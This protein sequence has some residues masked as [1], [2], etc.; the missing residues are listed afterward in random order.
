MAIRQIIT[1]YFLNEPRPGI[2]EGWG[3][4]L[5]LN[6]V[7]HAGGPVQEAIAPVHGAIAEFVA[8]CASQSIVAVSIAGDCCASIPVL[9]GLQR[10]ERNPVLVWLDAHGDFNTWDTSPSGFLGG[11]P[12]AMIAGRG[13]TKLMENVGAASLSESDIYLCDAR[14]LDPREAEALSSSDVNVCPDLDRLL[15]RLPV[16]ADVYV[17]FDSD[18]IDSREV[19]AQSYPVPGGPAASEVETFFAALAHKTNVVAASVSAWH[20]ERDE[21][22]GSARIVRRC[23]L[24]LMQ[25]IG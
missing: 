23:F 14:D 16:G 4:G 25:R 19:P 20:P 17:H 24:G 3:N 22:G 18:I 13:V 21:D 5:T 7:T 11:M 15:D 2:G 9:A 6:P 12:L 1:P 8:G 10:A